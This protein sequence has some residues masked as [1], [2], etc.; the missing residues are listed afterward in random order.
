MV[1]RTCLENRSVARHRGFESHPLRTGMKYLG[2][3]YGTKRIGV[4]VSD[5]NAMMAFPLGVVEAGKSALTEVLG[6]IQE[7]EVAVAVIGES[8]DLSGAPNPVQADIEAFAQALQAHGVA[9]E[10]EPEFLTS[11][12]SGRQFGTHKP[13]A[14][15]QKAS[16]P[17]HRDDSAAALILQSYLDRL[18]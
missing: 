3:D 9:V 10:F 6:I 18:R 4:A 15:Q 7:N 1:Y 13:T 5:E 2:I 14:R 8:R 17:E 12:Q 16:A 11:A